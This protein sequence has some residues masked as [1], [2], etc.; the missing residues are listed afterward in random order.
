M[1][2]DLHLS[3]GRS[4]EVSASVELCIFAASCLYVYRR[5]VSI[6]Q[7]ATSHANSSVAVLVVDTERTACGKKRWC[8]RHS[9]PTLSAP[10]KRK[11]VCWCCN[12]YW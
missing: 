3:I 2:A 4:G 12:R 1:A 6:C 10:D 9:S 11:A 5:T 8:P 7:M